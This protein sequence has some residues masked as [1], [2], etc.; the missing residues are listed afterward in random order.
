[1]AWYQNQGIHV[2]RIGPE[3]NF[4]WSE[5]VALENT[6][7]KEPDHFMLTEDEQGGVIISWGDT[8]GR[9]DDW[10][11]P[12]FFAP[13]PVYSQRLN[14][15]GESLWGTGALTGSG[16]LF[17]LRLSFPQLVTDGN[18]GVY[19]LWN[20]YK[21]ASRGLHDDYFRLQ[22]ISPE[23]QPVWEEP[24]KLLFASP[25]YH[26]TTPEEKAQGEKATITRPWPT[27]EDCKMA[28]DGRGGVIVVWQ[29]ETQHRYTN[30]SA[31]RYNT[32]GEPVW[33]DGGV[34]ICSAWDT[35]IEI[36]G[37]GDGGAVFVIGTGK[38]QPT[39]SSTYSVQRINSEGKLLWPDTGVP[40]EN[41]QQLWG[42]IGVAV[43]ATDII[44]FWQETTGK[45]EIID[46]SSIYQLA[47]YAKKISIAGDI[48]W[49]KDPLFISEAGKNFSN[50]ATYQSGEE[51]LLAWR[52]VSSELEGG[53]IFA[54]KMSMVD[55]KLIWEESGTAAFGEELRYQGP[56]VPVSDGS[57]GVII[58]IAA[59]ENPLDGDMVYAQ[60][61][62][63]AG[64][65]MW[66]EGIKV[67]R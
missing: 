23:G 18:G 52:L 7:L 39:Y 55:G 13:V 61:L 30:T 19:I 16:E 64:N 21:T 5:E 62:D 2:Q 51:L 41:K 59:G 29:D 28:G 33:D 24:G 43:Q 65:A 11:D 10:E 6:K 22:K 26:P 12:S 3:G 50:L 47:F 27:W 38:E 53:R 46:G 31:Q 20:D 34:P 58:L 14:A 56:P 1:M 63:A 44:V 54:Q 25:P 4:I 9:S 45:P 8:S 67:S 49:Q 35:T 37:D 40:V 57:G 42:S 66:G 36:I 60:R 48:V 32:D 17:G 15:S